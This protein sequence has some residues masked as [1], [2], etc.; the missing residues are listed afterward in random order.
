VIKIVAVFAWLAHS[1][2][3]AKIAKVFVARAP[4]LFVSPRAR[5]TAKQHGGTFPGGTIVRANLTGSPGL[6]HFL[7]EQNGA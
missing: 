4:M 2:Q 5:T 3:S 7:A 6:S 1:K